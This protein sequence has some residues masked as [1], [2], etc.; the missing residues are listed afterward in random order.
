MAIVRLREAWC[1][2]DSHRQPNSSEQANGILAAAGSPRLLLCDGDSR[3]SN[4]QVS[5]PRHTGSGRGDTIRG[6]TS[7]GSWRFFPPAI[8][9]QRP[10]VPDEQDFLAWP[11]NG[12]T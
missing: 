8:E 9:D 5:S 6:A 7:R 3:T 4:V 10:G 1:K 11:W 2:R 12:A